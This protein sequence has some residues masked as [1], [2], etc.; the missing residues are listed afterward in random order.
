MFLMDD[1]VTREV[2]QR[3]L[4]AGG[5]QVQAASLQEAIRE[6]FDCNHLTHIIA[7]PW[8]LESGDPR[9][10]EF[11]QW[12]NYERKV[13]EEQKRSA[14]SNGDEGTWK[15]F[16]TFLLHKLVSLQPI[17]E[18]QFD[19]SRK[20][21]KKEARARARLRRQ[22]KV[23]QEVKE[24][25]VDE[26]LEAELIILKEKI[27]KRNQDRS[28]LDRS[29]GGNPEVW[30]PKSEQKRKAEWDDDL[31]STG[32]WQT[33]QKRARKSAGWSLSLFAQFAHF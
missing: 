14:W 20:N 28:Y 29:R 5:G 30:R 8:I 17:E 6:E 3:I 22:I 15:I 18:V 21:I 26:E 2:Y 19:I 10:G 12:L 11:Q 32:S 33:S 24:E 13:T 1:P 4:E 31:S 25:E 9:Y 7:D 27:V 16:Y 23:K